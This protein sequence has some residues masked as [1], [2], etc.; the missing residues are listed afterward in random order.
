MKKSGKSLTFLYGRSTTTRKGEDI[1]LAGARI[2]KMAKAHGQSGK[3]DCHFTGG[4]S[5]AEDNI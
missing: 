5:M 2:V 1:R 3:N 4:E